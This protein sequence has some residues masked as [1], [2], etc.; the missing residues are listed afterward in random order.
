MKSLI[1]FKRYWNNTTISTEDVAGG[2]FLK[3]EVSEEGGSPD[4]VEK[5]ENHFRKDVDDIHLDTSFFRAP[6]RSTERN[7]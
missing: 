1:R 5:E 7:L 2:R 6:V 3:K 4:F